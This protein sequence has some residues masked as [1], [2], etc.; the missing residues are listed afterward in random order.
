MRLDCVAEQI[1]ADPVP[2]ILSDVAE[3]VQYAPKRVQN[4]V[5]EHIAA[6]PVPQ[7]SMDSMHA[8]QER[9]RNFVWEQIVDVPVPQ[10]NDDGRI[11]SWSIS[12][13]SL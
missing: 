11:A 3:D 5:V 9:V 4:L 6:D 1:L 8:P 13:Q 7:I 2:R 10:F 12:W